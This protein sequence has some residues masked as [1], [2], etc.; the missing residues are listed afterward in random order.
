[1]G[2][3]NAGRVRISWQ[4]TWDNAT[5]YVSQD[6]VYYLGETYVAIQDVSEDI[7]P[8]NATYWQKVAKKGTDGIDGDRGPEGPEGPE[9]PD[10]PQGVKGDTG[11]TGADGPQGPQGVKGTT[12]DVGPQGIQGEQ[13]V[14]P[15]HEWSGTELRFKNPDGSWGEYTFL[16]GPQGVEGPQGTKGD[17]GLTGP[18]GPEGPQ[19]P[20]GLQGIEGPQGEIGPVGPEG[21]QGTQGHNGINGEDGEK[22][23]IPQHMW[24]G[25][26]LRFQNNNGTWGEW[27]FLQG[28]TGP[29]GPRGIEGEKGN[30]PQHM[31]SGKDL[32]FQNNNGTWGEWTFLQGPPGPTGP[33]ADVMAD[34]AA[35]GFN[36]VGTYMWAI[37]QTETP[38][39]LAGE[40]TSGSNLTPE[41]N[42]TWRNMGRDASAPD[43]V[44]G[45][46]GPYTEGKP[47]L[48]LRIS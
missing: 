46:G 9:G 15:D 16:R 32:R 11:P 38:D 43:F 29:Q 36:T 22:G 45:P 13:G 42:G 37:L 23:N 3:I 10:G 18:A 7:N 39:V 34:V 1:M 4:G 31:W 2:V 35:A 40:T 30:I 33:A 41:A 28:P 24:R 47:S 19:G 14:A 48:F 8:T 20:Q 6:A 21:P 12:G 5:S 27:V 44:P 17:Q 26:D 25:K